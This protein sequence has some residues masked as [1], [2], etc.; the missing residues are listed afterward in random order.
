MQISIE[1]SAKRINYDQ[2]RSI[3]DLCFPNEP[4]A[5]NLYQEYV[6]ANFWAVFDQDTL[7]GYAVMKYIENNAHISR[8]CIHPAYRSQGLGHQLMTEILGAATNEGVHKVTLLVQQDNPAAIRL[9]QKHNFQIEGE[10][11]QFLVPIVSNTENRSA[12]I[13]IDE[14]RNGQVYTP[15]RSADNGLGKTP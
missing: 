1:Q 14:Y 11:V 10:S 6:M 9:Y 3:N 8:I 12:V 4:V 13:P 15:P 5:E 2:F 7:I